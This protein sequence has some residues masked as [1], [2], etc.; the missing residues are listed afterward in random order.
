MNKYCWFDLKSLK[1]QEKHYL[2]CCP[3]RE[4]GKKL[5]MASF[6]KS[7]LKYCQQ[8]NH[9]NPRAIGRVFRQ[10]WRNLLCWMN[11]LLAE[12]LVCCLTR[13]S[14]LKVWYIYLH[15]VSLGGK[16]RWYLYICIYTPY[17]EPLGMWI[18]ELFPNSRK[19]TLPSTKT[20]GIMKCHRSSDFLQGILFFPTWKSIMAYPKT[21]FLFTTRF[22]FFS[23]S[24]KYGPGGRKYMKIYQIYNISDVFREISLLDDTTPLFHDRH[25]PLGLV[26]EPGCFR[27][28]HR[29]QILNYP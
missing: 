10:C 18:I 29:L 14:L 25:V 20:L 22:M 21:R 9:G 6:G 7:K 12:S 28:F 5:H 4:A 1:A 23:T 3:G 13:S 15:L 17:I 24:M 19:R 26:V 16:R 8:T 11:L 27:K 2:S